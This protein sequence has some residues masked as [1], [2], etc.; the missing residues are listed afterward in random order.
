M[1]NTKSDEKSKRRFPTKYE[2]VN[3][4]AITN[5]EAGFVY[6]WCREDFAKAGKSAPEIRGWIPVNHNLGDTE[7]VVGSDSGMSSD[8]LVRKGNLILCKSTEEWKQDRMS[9]LERANSSRVP[10]IKRKAIKELEKLRFE[11]VGALDETKSK[12]IK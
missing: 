5:P 9:K 6:R 2:Y 7:S 8:G 10:D 11:V 12:L 1:T 4:L 3:T